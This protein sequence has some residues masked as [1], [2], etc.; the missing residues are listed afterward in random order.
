M[1]PDHI[2]DAFR[3]EDPRMQPTHSRT[4]DDPVL[5]RAGRKY[6]IAELTSILNR[7]KAVSMISGRG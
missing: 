5:R 3:Y 2:D 1:E 6:T 7:L 4:K